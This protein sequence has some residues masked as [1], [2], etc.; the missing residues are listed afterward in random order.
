MPDIY[1]DHNA[2]APQANPNPPQGQ[3]NSGQQPM[4]SPLDY[5]SFLQ[6]NADKVQPSAEVRAKN[7][8]INTPFHTQLDTTLK[9]TDP[10]I[11]YNPFDKNLEDKYANAHPLSSPINSVVKGAAKFLSGT[12][13]ALSTIPTALYSLSTGDASNFY[14]NAFYKSIND[15]TG[16]LDKTLP[17]YTS[18][19]ET[20]HP[21]S[22]YLAIWHPT[23]FFNSVGKVVDNLGFMGGTILGAGL[24]DYFTGGALSEAA[25]SSIGN[26][27]AKISGRLGRTLA[28]AEDITQGLKDITG[29]E[30]AL[31]ATEVAGRE[32]VN[33]INGVDINDINVKLESTAKA[34]KLVDNTRAEL[35]HVTSALTMGAIGGAET[36][37]NGVQQLSQDYYDKYGYSPTGKDLEDIKTQTRDVAN[38]NLF[39]TTAL[40]YFTSKVNWGNLFKPSGVAIQN[41]LDKTITDG[42]DKSVDDA[43]NATY[44]IAA[45]TPETGLSKAIGIVKSRVSTEAV[46]SQTAG[47]ASLGGITA[48]NEGSLD[49]LKRKY[50]ANSRGQVADYATS[51]NDGLGTAFGTNQ[52]WDGLIT[53]AIAGL[54]THGIVNKI[55]QSK[56]AETDPQKRLLQ[57]VQLLNQYKL[58]GIFEHKVQEASLA[59]SL[60]QEHTQAATDENIFKVKNLNHDHF[61]SWVEGGVRANNFDARIEEL[62]SLKTLNPQAFA[63]RWGVE[64]TQENKEKAVSFID[65]TISKAKEIK[66][67]FDNVDQAYGRNP[68]N[69]NTQ[70]QDWLSHE[71]RK[72]DLVRY[73]SQGRDVRERLGG[74]QDSINSVHSSFNLRD[75][76]LMT[77]P[78]GQQKILDKLNSN[79]DILNDS[80]SKTVG[81]PEMAT[82]LKQK[83]DSL[84]ILHDEFKAQIDKG[85]DSDTFMPTLSK[86]FALHRGIDYQNN[87]YLNTTVPDIGNALGL[88][89]IDRE[90][91]P[92]TNDLLVD[93]FQKLIDFNRLENINKQTVDTYN[94]LLT[95]KG[96]LDYHSYANKLRASLAA[97]NPLAERVVTPDA[98]LNDDTL[99][100]KKLAEVKLEQSDVVNSEEDPKELENGLEAAQPIV[101]AAA[102]KIAKGQELTKDEAEAMHTFPDAFSKNLQL[103]A[104]AQKRVEAIRSTAETSVDDVANELGT[105]IQKVVGE[106]DFKGL[107]PSAVIFGGVSQD[108][109]GKGE[110]QVRSNL[111]NALFTGSLLTNLFVTLSHYNKDNGIPTDPN[112]PLTKMTLVPGS[113]GVYRKPLD[114]DINI[115]PSEV[116]GDDKTDRSK[117]ISIVSPPNGLYFKEGSVYK[118]IQDA[119]KEQYATITGNSQDTHEQFMQHLDSYTNS[120]NKLLDYINTKQ[121]TDTNK[122]PAITRAELEQFFDVKVNYGTR[123]QNG[124]YAKSLDT[125]IGDMRYPTKDAILISARGEEKPK[126]LNRENFDNLPKEKKQQIVDAINANI[127]NIKRYGVIFPKPDGSF[128]PDSFVFGRNA[129]LK[130]PEKQDFF[131]TI[132]S[133]TGK[134]D[135]VTDYATLPTD[136]ERH[137]AIEDLNNKFFY[138]NAGSNIKNTYFRFDFD[139][140]ANLLIHIHNDDKGINTYVKVDRQE[141]ND[142]KIATHDDLVSLLNTKINEAVV[143]SKDKK[144]DGAKN[145][146]RLDIKLSDPDAIKKQ[147]PNDEDIKSIDDVKDN[148]KLT[149]TPDLFTNY[150]LNFVPKETP[151]EGLDNTSQEQVQAQEVPNQTL[152]NDAVTK[153]RVSNYTSDSSLKGEKNILHFNQ[154][155]DKNRITFLLDADQKAEYVAAKANT[156]ALGYNDE[157]TGPSSHI[158]KQI[159]KAFRADEGKDKIINLKG[160][161]LTLPA[162][163]LIKQLKGEFIKNHLQVSIAKGKDTLKTIFK[164]LFNLPT[165]QADAVANVY[166][167]N[168]KAW[169]KEINSRLPE[170]AKPATIADYYSSRQF[171]K[172]TQADLEGSTTQFQANEPYKLTE[173]DQPTITLTNCP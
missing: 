65:N 55:S 85:L 112:N 159:A 160:L 146:S 88:L 114:Q 12:V 15:Y 100:A 60:G 119:S 138:E 108:Y 147:I 33:P 74:L 48:I 154:G 162:D 3:D 79:I 83:A 11:G 16:Q 9:Y 70:L 50:D 40:M 171:A 56:G 93:S 92:I 95:K 110:P 141:V 150:T 43:G 152:A 102:I 41:A 49:Y 158:L 2:V 63:E 137:Q 26:A 78:E 73:L 46:A 126:I 155:S 39:A 135:G 32:I 98:A 91:A 139:K 66:Q 132:R 122:T 101:Q 125:N 99:F 170:G 168:A 117:K 23:G 131:D 161:D 90:K 128:Q 153:P 13:Q 109:K 84:Q 169:V 5:L 129:N 127:N 107:K 4:P 118:P 151:K 72:S 77:S 67:G 18:Q 57:Q 103:A 113:F 165:E 38:F 21:I 44:K 36:M 75:A 61:F 22:K 166:N 104:E 29:T 59:N 96:A 116:T 80:G 62:Q 52:G 45:K 1:S 133:I 105:P 163:E 142:P 86:L 106:G 35:A 157:K 7:D 51:F 144:Y 82:M 156:P 94:A 97:N 28:S 17:T 115:Y 121:G 34:A 145:L 124:A 14:D 58:D 24:E 120:Y 143:N 68:F 172:S 30:K 87:D 8:A 149:T 167:E 164:N 53:G 71:D 89:H 111:Y 134:K 64:A 25:I 42:I 37:K 19:Y 136:E 10:N 81:D 130:E 20:D 54:I 173:Q 123:I 76:L 6:G 27:A 140:D 47:A 31:G 69:R 148:I